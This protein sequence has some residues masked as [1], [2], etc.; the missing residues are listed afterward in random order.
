MNCEAL[1]QGDVHEIARIDIKRDRLNPD[2]L[3]WTDPKYICR[4]V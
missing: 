4:N 1:E 2:A 3:E